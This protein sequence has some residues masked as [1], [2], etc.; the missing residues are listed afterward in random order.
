MTRRWMTWVGGAACC[1]V[2]G[3]LVFRATTVYSVGSQPKI[4]RITSVRDL[5]DSIEG[6]TT[7]GRTVE[8]WYRQ[9]NFKE[10]DTGGG[11]PFSWCT[12]KHGGQKVR[13]ATVTADASGVFR[14]SNLASASNSVP[15]FPPAPGDDRCRG[16]LFTELLPRACD[17]PGVHCSTDH[18]PVLHWLNVK[19]LTPTTGATAGSVSQADQAAIAFADGPDDDNSMSNHSDVSF[20]AVDTTIGGMVRGQQVTWR[21]GATGTASCPSAPVYDASTVLESDAEYPF[22]LGTV[23]AHGDG[24]SIVA[25]A[26]IPRGSELGPNINVDVT[27]KLRADANIN[28]G[29]DQPKPFDFL[30]F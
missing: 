11:D 23:Q 26:K 25:S 9:R 18:A 4:Y 22:I 24:G 15:L 21:C 7:P 27:V 2:L 12:W 19:H 3:M 10:G 5:L 8:I 16:G 6:V 29:C 30:P 17:A 28:L 14:V 13:L 20:H 1:A